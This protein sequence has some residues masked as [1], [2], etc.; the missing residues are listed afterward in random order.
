MEFLSWGTFLAAL[1]I[2]GL[3]V[4]S[5]S[6]NRHMLFFLSNC[7]MGIA[8]LRFSFFPMFVVGLLIYPFLGHLQGR[9][10]SVLVY[11]LCILSLVPL[12]VLRSEMDLSWKGVW[13]SASLAFFCLQNCGAVFEI[14]WNRAE[15][16]KS[17]FLW[18]SFSTFFPSLVAGPVGRWSM[19]GPQ[20]AAPRS[21]QTNDGR[22]YILL[23]AQGVFKKIVFA[24]PLYI[25][26]DRFFAA[27][28]EFG[29]IAALVVAFLFRYAIWADISAHTDWAHGIA[30]I[31]GVR[32]SS[33]FDNPFHTARLA[34]FWRRWHSSLSRWLQDFV[35]MP[36]AFGPLRRLLPAKLAM[37]IA[38]LIAFACLGLW[39]GL[40]AGLLV[41]GLYKGIGV[42]VAE[43]IWKSLDRKNFTYRFFQI[44]TGTLMMIVFMV[45]PTLLIRMS[46]EDAIHI[47]TNP[48]LF[49]PTS[50][51]KLTA[52]YDAEI[53]THKI[54]WPTFL[55][56]V[57]YEGLQHFSKVKKV[58]NGSEGLE[59]RSIVSPFNDWTQVA[60][61]S[62]AIVVFFVFG[63]FSAWL[64]FSY[65][66]H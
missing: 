21:F 7:L 3:S 42:L 36:L 62:L 31:I 27:P 10:R 18:M 35:F 59:P 13:L 23:L 37:V 20:L 12:I 52:A 53:E 47:F 60:L 57:A 54:L 55:I 24:A 16:P 39:H 4:S 51:L 33:N 46:L 9:L 61:I 49:W 58:A 34:D 45:F 43:W 26:I 19:L 1:V 30:R 8:L 66:N 50:W 40:A 22:E 56:A 15:A 25:V 6:A 28:K 38:L 44:C 2:G 14:Y 41:M 11:P 65:V 29:L 17:V 64:G 5:C 63:S 32:L 48:D